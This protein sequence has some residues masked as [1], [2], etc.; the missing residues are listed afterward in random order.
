MNTVISTMYTLQYTVY[1]IQFI[2]Y[3]VDSILL[4]AWSIIKISSAANRLLDVTTYHFA[5]SSV[6]CTKQRLHFY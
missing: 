2:L 6:Y 1:S 4:G 3:T 5:M